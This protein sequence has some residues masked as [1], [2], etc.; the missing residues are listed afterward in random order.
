M[1]QH[2]YEQ[3]IDVCIATYA[4][5]HLDVMRHFLPGAFGI[6]PFYLQSLLGLEAKFLV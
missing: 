2:P 3:D 5:C 4:F 1:S 6:H